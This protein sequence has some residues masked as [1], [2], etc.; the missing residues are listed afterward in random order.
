MTRSIRSLL[1]TLM[2]MAGLIAGSVALDL[3][4]GPVSASE[5][6]GSPQFGGGVIIRIPST[7]RRVVCRYPAVYN[8]RK[9]RCGCVPGYKKKRGRCI[10]RSGR[11]PEVARCGANSHLIRS[12]RRCGCNRGYTRSGRR[13]V[14]TRVVKCGANAWLNKRTSRCSCKRGYT[15]SGR[16]CVRPPRIVDCRRN[17]FYSKR[18][19]S[20]NCKRGYNRIDGACKKPPRIVSC[21]IN[22]SYSK[23]TKSCTCRDGYVKID[24]ACVA[25]QPPVDVAEEPP[26]KVTR[27]APVNTPAPANCL[28]P[29]LYDVLLNTYGRKPDV[30]RCESSCLARPV[31]YSADRLDDMTA[32]F[33]VNWCKSC[34]SFGGFMP[35]GDIKRL[36]KLIGQPVCMRGGAQ[37][38]SAPGYAHVDPQVTITKV[39]NIIKLYPKTI[40][41]QGDI[42]VIIGN[43]TYQGGA[44]AN[45]NAQSDADAVV[46][47]LT[48]SLGYKKTNIIDLRNATLDDMQRVFGGKDGTPGEL[49]QLYGSR[50]SGGVFVYISSHGLRD[51]NTGINYI[52]PVNGRQRDLKGTA[53][54]LADLY[55]SLGKIGATT[56][57]LALETSFGSDLTPF[58]DP[59]N[60]PESEKSVLPAK[61]IPGLA[62]F[63][64]SDR[65]QRTL[66]DPEF[67]IGLFTRY[68][69]EGMAGKADAGPTG[70]GDNRIDSVE[71][72]VYTASMVRT[73]A[74]KS[75]GLEQKPLLSKIE[76]ILIGQLARR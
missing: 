5:G 73:A 47:L 72:Y 52:L 33:G 64:A 24:G 20:C 14:R 18:S 61:P 68:L 28:S 62:V 22:S 7:R 43:E 65:D 15:R 25:S 19:K 2:L 37:M 60:L 56:V 13:C 17:E 50:K 54:P 39:Q 58:I 11:R 46:E 31:G 76:N 1:V 66:D 70:N 42:A 53:Y 23:R 75:L 32:R 45:A 36:E 4:P 35:L 40:G 51:D 38:C 27:A 10:P 48:S 34:V 74:R 55:A 6:S 16:K 44:M 41:K 69:I 12:S 26:V 21:G 29:D 57:M 30:E 8:A 9:G 49:Q 71:L 59:P 67:G 3:V 63:T